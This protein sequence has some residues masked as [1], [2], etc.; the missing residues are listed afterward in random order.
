MRLCI[1][2]L[3][4]GENGANSRGALSRSLSPNVMES[5]IASGSDPRGGS[6]GATRALDF[7]FRHPGFCT[8]SERFK[9][10][11]VVEI[12]NRYLGRMTDVI[13]ENKG[14]SRQI[15]RRRD[16]RP[17]WNAAR[18]SESRQ[19]RGQA[20]FQMKKALAELRGMECQRDSS[21]SRS[22]ARDQ[23][24]EV[25]VGNI[26]SEK[27]LEYTVIGDNVNLASPLE[28]LTKQYRVPLIIG[29]RTQEL[30]RCGVLP[31]APSILSV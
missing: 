3:S 21:R 20:A 19:V 18:G 5:L 9:P 14:H 10:E 2:V 16:F 1:L 11:F 17:F 22:G 28:G 23:H 30:L 8:F 13:F 27:R 7:V 12:L 24:G 25:I 26:G 6:R 31:V 29:Q 4:K 15:Y